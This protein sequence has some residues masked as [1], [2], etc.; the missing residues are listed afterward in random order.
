MNSS[1]RALIFIYSAP[2]QKQI[3]V[4]PRS[5]HSLWCNTNVQMLY[6]WYARCTYVKVQSRWGREATRIYIMGYTS[7]YA[8]H[9]TTLNCEES[10]QRRA[11]WL[12]ATEVT[13]REAEV[14]GGS[15]SWR[16]RFLERACSISARGS[17]LAAR[18]LIMHNIQL[19]HV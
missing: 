3:H 8:H 6:T 15:M 7:T 19:R 10:C 5:Q 2:Q 11:R 18:F 14:R 13:V 12:C 1:W 17:R 4:A 9:T 16:L